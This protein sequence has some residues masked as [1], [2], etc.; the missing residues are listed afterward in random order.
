MSDR[1][2]GADLSA[3]IVAAC[4]ARGEFTGVEIMAMVPHAAPPAVRSIISRLVARDVIHVGG[5]RVVGKRHIA[6]YRFGPRPLGAAAVVVGFPN[7]LPAETIDNAARLAEYDRKWRARIG[8]TRAFSRASAND[9]AF[10]RK[11]RNGAQAEQAD[12]L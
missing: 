12:G 6:L 9:V 2:D 8:D 5:V 7:A 3:A 11:V 1:P 4:R 10:I